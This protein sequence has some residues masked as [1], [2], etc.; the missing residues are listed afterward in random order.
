MQLRVANSYPTGFHE[1]DR[2][3]VI[4]QEDSSCA[5]GQFVEFGDE[6]KAAQFLD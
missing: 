3:V 6:S 4:V 2:Y 1:R 5:G